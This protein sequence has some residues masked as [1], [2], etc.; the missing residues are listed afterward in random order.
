MHEDQDQAK[1]ED[2]DQDQEKI[3]NEKICKDQEKI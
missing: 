2:K 3:Y 1:D